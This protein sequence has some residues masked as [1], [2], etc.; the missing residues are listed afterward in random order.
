[1]QDKDGG[2]ETRAWW[3]EVCKN[4]KV[5]PVPTHS[6]DAPRPSGPICVPR[7]LRKDLPLEA[8]SAASGPRGGGWRS[9][10]WAGETLAPGHVGFPGLGTKP[11]LASE[12]N[13]QERWR[14]SRERRRY[15]AGGQEGGERL[16]LR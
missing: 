7:E 14:D 6:R 15:V 11:G 5:P 13:S 16:E 12:I 4:P 3:G 8:R 10:P 1:M 2:A 9:S